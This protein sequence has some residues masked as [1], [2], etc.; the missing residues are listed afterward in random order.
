MSVR[1]CSKP[2]AP[3]AITIAASTSSTTPNTARNAPLV[4]S[5][6]TASASMARPRSWPTP[7]RRMSS[8]RMRKEPSSSRDLSSAPASTASCPLP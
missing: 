5:A 7:S 1:I 4:P 8:G 2:A 3:N 6:S